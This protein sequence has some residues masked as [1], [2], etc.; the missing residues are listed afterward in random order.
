MEGYDRWI[1]TRFWSSSGFEMTWRFIAFVL[2]GQACCFSSFSRCS[3]SWRATWM[4]CERVK[5]DC[6]TKSIRKKKIC[7]KNW[8]YIRWSTKIAEQK[9]DL[10]TF[11]KTKHKK[12]LGPCFHTSGI[13]ENAQAMASLIILVV[14]NWPNKSFCSCLVQPKNA[15]NLWWRKMTWHGGANF[16]SKQIRGQP[17]CR[18]CYFHSHSTCPCGESETW[19]VSS[20]TKHCNKNVKI[21]SRAHHTSKANF[22]HLFHTT[23]CSKETNFQ[24]PNFQNINSRIMFLQKCHRQYSTSSSIFFLKFLR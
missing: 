4:A 8:S 1:V 5:T 11:P 17:T 19:S 16:D 2:S 23:V 10:S 14:L 6:F 3:N 15:W 9:P 21:E 20:A 22:T 24:N 7:Q 12:F 13:A 18:S